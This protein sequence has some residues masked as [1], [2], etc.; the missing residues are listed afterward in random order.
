MTVN[1]HNTYLPI[2]GTEWILND[3]YPDKERIQTPYLYNVGTGQRID[4]AK[5][6][7]PIDYKNEWRCDLHPRASRDGRLVAIDSTHE[8]QGRQQYVIDIGGIVG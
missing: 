4:L 2:R 3:T 6:H 1:G 5:F 8:G 7:S